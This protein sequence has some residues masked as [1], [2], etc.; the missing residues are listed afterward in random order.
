MDETA[1]TNILYS[2]EINDLE[3][4]IFEKVFGKDAVNFSQYVV[5]GGSV[6]YDVRFIIESEKLSDFTLNSL[7]LSVKQVF[8]QAK[9]IELMVKLGKSTIVISNIHKDQKL[10]LTFLNYNTKEMLSEEF[11]EERFRKLLK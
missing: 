6:S 10:H 8:S 3:K 5:K 9:R 11:S 4:G 2:P 1:K 7:V